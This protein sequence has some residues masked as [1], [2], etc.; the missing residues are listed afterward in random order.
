MIDTGT[1]QYQCNHMFGELYQGPKPPQGLVL[2]DAG[3]HVLIL[4]AADYQ[5]PADRFPTLRV[6]SAAGDDDD[7]EPI[8][9]HQLENYWNGA[10]AAAAALHAGQRVLVTC[11]AGLNRS[12]IV[13]ALTLH[14]MTGWAGKRCAEAIRLRRKGALFNKQFSSYLDSLAPVE[15]ITPV[16]I[17]NNE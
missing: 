15:P 14:L 5:P 9:A 12:G 2:R 7:N 8:P 13:S 10:K 4:A 1:G 6:I 16:Q 17:D 3:F 11:Y